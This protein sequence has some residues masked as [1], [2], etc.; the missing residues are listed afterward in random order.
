MITPE[1]A[2]TRAYRQIG[3]GIYRLGSGGM[4]P[5][6]ASP[7]NVNGECDCSGFTSWVQGYSRKTSHPLYVKFNGGWIN[8]DAIVHDLKECTGIFRPL[9]EPKVGAL[10]VYGRVGSR[11]GHVGIISSLDPVRVIH[12][13]KGNYVN[14][15][16]AIQE[17]SDKVFQN[18]Y[19][20]I[21]WYEGYANA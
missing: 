19:T 2:L 5:S 20:K 10:L 18:I 13:S 4:D 7:L 12:C 6:A 14:T 9:E 3:K 11:V 21:A 15:G 17:T 1:Q 16:K 8:T